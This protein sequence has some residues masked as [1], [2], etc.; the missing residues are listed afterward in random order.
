MTEKKELLTLFDAAK[1]LRDLTIERNIVHLKSQIAQTEA[2][3]LHNRA[4]KL[5]HEVM[6]ASGDLSRTAI[7]GIP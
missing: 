2:S 7:E 3:D 5:D 6:M 1:R 4:R